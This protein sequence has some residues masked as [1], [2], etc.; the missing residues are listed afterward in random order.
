M[1]R[2]LIQRTQRGLL[3]K[4]PWVLGQEGRILQMK[5]MKHHGLASQN[6]QWWVRLRD[7]FLWHVSDTHIEKERVILVREWQEEKERAAVLRSFTASR[8]T[9]STLIGKGAVSKKLTMKNI[10][11][12]GITGVMCLRS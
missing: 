12:A 6:Q 4:W 10:R 2:R 11:S 9:A 8:S 1:S 3:V 5:E 7:P